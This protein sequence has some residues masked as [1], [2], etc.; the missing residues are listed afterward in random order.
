MI[1]AGVV[2]AV[3]GEKVED[4]AS[5]FGVQFGAEAATVLDVHAEEAEEARPLGVDEVAVSGIGEWR[6]GG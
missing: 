2:D 1:V 6:G 5:V 3:A 4:D